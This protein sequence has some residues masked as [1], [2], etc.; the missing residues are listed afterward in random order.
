MENNKSPKA[1]S[2]IAYLWW[3][4]WIIA[5]IIRDKDDAGTKQHLNQALVAAII[6]IIGTLLIWIPVV[7]LV[8]E[9]AGAILALWGLIRAIKGNDEPMPYIGGIKIIK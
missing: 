6:E 5:F 7:G 1:A 8:L 2:I 4:G 9:V 3:I